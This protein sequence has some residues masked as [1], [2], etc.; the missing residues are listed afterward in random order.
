MNIE[1]IRHAY[2][3]D[4]TLG[5]LFVGDDAFPAIERP[6]IENENGLGGKP[7]ESCV[8][9]GF[10]FLAPHDSEK[11][12]GTYRLENDELGVYGLTR[13][14]GQNWGRT[15]ILIHAGNVVNDVIGCI[16]IGTK[17]GRSRGSRAVLYSRTA[18]ARLNQL[19]E[20]KEHEL[21]I[22]PTHGTG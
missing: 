15:A 4:M 12:P 13:P 2:L 21:T 8:P 18:M 17:A 11:F 14:I 10:Y 16:A 5:T 20:R 6:W 1:L 7:S 9:D 19:L 22:R 3:N